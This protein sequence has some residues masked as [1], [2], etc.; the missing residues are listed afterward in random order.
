M[1]PDAD[2]R[3]SYFHLTQSKLYCMN[4]NPKL[5]ANVTRSLIILFITFSSVMIGNKPSVA[6]TT[7]KGGDE[8]STWIR[9]LDSAIEKSKETNRPIML[10]FSG[11]DWCHWCQRLEREILKTAEFD[12]WSADSV[13]K[14]MV[15][16]PANR[17]LPDEIAAQNEYLKRYF[18][19]HVEGF[20]TI[21]FVEPGGSV[22][23]KSGFVSGGPNAWIKKSNSILE[24]DR[25]AQKRQ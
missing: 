22:I 20:P 21:L 14:M 24:K 19:D 6:Q 5:S 17:Q 12:R 9:D 8:S 4:S 13:I 16:F 7:A 10:V 18:A 25:L 15:D 1:S 2:R 11:S 3:D 23:G